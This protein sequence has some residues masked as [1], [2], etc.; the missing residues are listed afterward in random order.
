MSPAFKGVEHVNG[1]AATGSVFTC[2]RQSIGGEP[3]GHYPQVVFDRYHAAARPTRPSTPLAGPRSRPVRNSTQPLRLA[4]ERR[5]PHRRPALTARR[6]VCRRPGRPERDDFNSLLRP[7]DA[8]GP[9]GVSAPLVRRRET[10]TT[11]A[12]EDLRPTRRVPP[13]R[14][15]RPATQPD[16]QRVS[17]YVAPPGEVR[18]VV[19][20]V[21]VSEAVGCDV[22]GL[23]PRWAGP[24]WPG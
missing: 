23:R 13:G 19:L 16:Q 2:R 17:L 8:G 15:H 11:R 10:I 1:A 6:C 12:G 4:E 24:F 21:L 9:R 5:G 7:A 3:E 18:L 14:D 20:V 22:S